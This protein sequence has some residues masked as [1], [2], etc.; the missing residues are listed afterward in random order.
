MHIGLLELAYMIC[1][2]EV[3]LTLSRAKKESVV[4]EGLPNNVL[5]CRFHEAPECSQNSAL[6][7][8]GKLFDEF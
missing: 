6:I 4:H 5:L 2:V 8:S 7:L 3:H 1:F